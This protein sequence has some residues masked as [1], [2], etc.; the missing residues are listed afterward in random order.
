MS[1]F[2]G[3]LI[4]QFALS[5]AV[6]DLFTQLCVAQLYSTDFFHFFF[7]ARTKLRLT[8]SPTPLSVCPVRRDATT[9]RTRRRA[10]P[11]LIGP[12]ERLYC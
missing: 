4:V 8:A 1:H 5:V 9:V 7:A 11:S 12:C 6:D 10:W 2:D 3:P